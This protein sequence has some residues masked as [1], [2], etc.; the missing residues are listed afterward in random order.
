MYSLPGKVH[1][2]IDHIKR[3]MNLISNSVPAEVRHVELTFL[4]YVGRTLYVIG[5]Y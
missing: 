2:T 5:T 1:Y 4:A 3:L